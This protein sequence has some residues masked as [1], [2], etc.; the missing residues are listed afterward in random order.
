MLDSS[1]ILRVLNTHI[2]CKFVKFRFLEPAGVIFQFVAR[3]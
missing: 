2:D 1:S 3:N